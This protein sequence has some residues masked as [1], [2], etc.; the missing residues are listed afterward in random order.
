MKQWEKELT[1]AVPKI[2]PELK[3]ETV[4]KF[5]LFGSEILKWNASVNLISRRDSEKVL[6]RL[7]LDS[8]FLLRIL[9]GIGPFLDLGSGAG[10]PSIPV[11]LGHPMK[12]T[13]T[14]GRKRRAAFLNHLLRILEIPDVQIM[15]QVVTPATT[16]LPFRFDYL[17]S[18]AAVPLNKLLMGAGHWLHEGGTLILF[19][20]FHTKEEQNGVLTLAKE[21]HLVFVGCQ[22]FEYRPLALVRTL[23][24]FKK[25]GG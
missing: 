3:G 4:A 25:A 24:L 8:L 7:T 23:T 11:I 6:V 16:C 10:F 15:N 1:N 12:G 17:W 18:K 20:P 9:Q 19:R 14:E 22:R 13:L 2:F 21:H 5:L